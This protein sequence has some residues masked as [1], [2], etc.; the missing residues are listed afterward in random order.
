MTGAVALLVL[1]FPLS[2]Q[3]LSVSVT[4]AMSWF[5]SAVPA[6]EHL[7]DG[8]LLA[9]AVVT[10]AVGAWAW[11][12]R[13]DRRQV[14]VWAAGGVVIAY[15]TSEGLKLLLAQ[16]RPCTRWSAVGKCD[17]SDFSLPSNHAALAFA[18]VIVIAFATR[19][20]GITLSAL[21]LAFLVGAARM[22]EGAHYLH[23][24][25]AGALIG[26]AVP[27]FV[28]WAAQRMRPRPTGAAR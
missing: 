17:A 25:A 3:S 11:R 23:D 20:G 15:A 4:R 18:A 8:A 24:V 7:S 14:T 1:F 10:A 12:R 2:G 28:A 16:P 27:A 5:G 19:G 22:L 13:P 21:L 26:L 9:L 6:V